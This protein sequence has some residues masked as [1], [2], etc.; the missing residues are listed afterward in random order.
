MCEFDLSFEDYVHAIRNGSFQGVSSVLTNMSDA[1]TIT[2]F[3]CN[4]RDV[5]AFNVFYPFFT[6][7]KLLGCNEL[8][9]FVFLDVLAVFPPA[10][11]AF[12]SSNVVA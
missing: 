9:F 5:L 12:T 2:V 4:R 1:W 11:V 10:G 7:I 3:H 8:A 6:I